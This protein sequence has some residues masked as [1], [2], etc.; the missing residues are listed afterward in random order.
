[1]GRWKSLILVML[2]LIV[3]YHMSRLTIV[4]A[5]NPSRIRPS[6]IPRPLFLYYGF[7]DSS[8]F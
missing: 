5:H 6:S 1:M 3:S 2:F 7:P 8:F 4:I